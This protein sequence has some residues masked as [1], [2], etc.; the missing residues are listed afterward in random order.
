MIL[1]Q[2]HRKSQTVTSHYRVS[3]MNL[4][5]NLDLI[6]KVNILKS[7]IKLCIKILNCMYT[8][9]LVYV[10]YTLLLVLDEIKFNFYYKNIYLNIY[11]IHVTLLYCL[12]FEK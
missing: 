5:F 6:K 2:V 4:K 12:N 3:Q 8:I 9:I 1:K 7:S 10:W 11:Y